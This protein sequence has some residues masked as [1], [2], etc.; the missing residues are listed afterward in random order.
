MG[1]A[2][3]RSS[4]I[5]SS[6]SIISSSCWGSSIEHRILEFE[7]LPFRAREASV[8]SSEML[9]EG[10]REIGVLEGPPREL[11]KDEA[12]DWEKRDWASW[13]CEYLCWGVV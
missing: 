13:A 2:R 10:V 11:L 12:M 4:T 5:R 6:S 3:R 1:E 9:P 8:G 7:E